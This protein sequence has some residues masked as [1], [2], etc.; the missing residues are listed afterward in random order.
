MNGLFST[1]FWKSPTFYPNP[2]AFV[3]RL[4]TLRLLQ[5][6]SLYV[7]PAY[8]KGVDVSKGLA[9]ISGFS[10]SRSNSYSGSLFFCASS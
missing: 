1:R 3:G 5:A 2:F 4:I 9:Q 7:S 6:E 8:G 10:L